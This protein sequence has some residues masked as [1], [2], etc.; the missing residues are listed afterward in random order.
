MEDTQ[1]YIRAPWTLH[2][3]TKPCTTALSDLALC[4]GQENRQQNNNS[5]FCFQKKKNLSTQIKSLHGG[6][7][8]WGTTFSCFL[9]AFADAE[10]VS[11]LWTVHLIHALILVF[12]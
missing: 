5:E 7:H 2:K 11:R 3:I 8:D 9:L 10:V 4:Q 6:R 1:T 12:V